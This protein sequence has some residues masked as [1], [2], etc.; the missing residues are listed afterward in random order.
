MN[1]LAI[2]T[3]IKGD[4]GVGDN[5]QNNLIILRNKSIHKNFFG[6][7]DFIIFHEGNVSEEYKNTIL[8]DSRIKFPIKFIEVNNFKPSKEEIEKIKHSLI[9]RTVVQ[10]GYSSMCKFWSYGFIDYLKEYDY[11]IRIDDDCV[12]LNDISPIVEELKEKYLVFPF[13]TGESYRYRLK[14]FV[15]QYFIKNKSIDEDKIKGPYTNFCGFNLNKIRN[16]VHIM[17]FFNTIEIN[18]FV[19]RYSWQDV[20]LWGLVME[21]ILTEEDWSENRDIKYIHLSHLNFVN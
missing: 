11:V 21:Y 14:D 5:W 4:I 16:N 20:Q 2:A 8:K 12:A 9:D 7:C 13:L 6:D 17:D 3:L 10:T 1:K 19:Y 18:N 15:K